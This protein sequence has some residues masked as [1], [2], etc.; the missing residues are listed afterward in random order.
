MHRNE[1]LIF[2]RI[3]I[4]TYTR[5]YIF[6]NINTDNTN[7]RREEYKI[8][9]D[10]HWKFECLLNFCIADLERELNRIDCTKKVEYIKSERQVRQWRSRLL[11]CNLIL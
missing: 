1:E 6:T 9:V 10:L 8:K 11:L 2:L 7:S 3:Y 4:I 5:I